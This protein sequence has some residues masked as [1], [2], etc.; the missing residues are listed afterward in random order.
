VTR[1]PRPKEG[2]IRRNSHPFAQ[3]LSAGPAPGRELPRGLGV[4]TAG[5]KRFWRTWSTAPQTANWAETDWTELEITVRLVDRFYQGEDK[6][7]SEIR[8]RV[9]K[10]GAT[11][12]DRARLRM[13]F[14]TPSD[15]DTEESADVTNIDKYRKA[16]G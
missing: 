13:T 8:M 9:S 6:L 16:F 15:D 7:A 14:E 3:E 10:W 12:E 2:A 1:G 5:A 4:K 11:V